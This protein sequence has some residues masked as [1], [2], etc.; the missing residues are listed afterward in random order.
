MAFYKIELEQIQFS[1]GYCQGRRIVHVF[2]IWLYAKEQTMS[3][4]YNEIVWIISV[5]F[6]STSTASKAIFS[7]IQE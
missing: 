4:T 3:L 1:E 5:S 2:L 7:R 6:D